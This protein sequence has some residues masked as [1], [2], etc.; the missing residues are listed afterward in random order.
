MPPSASSNRPWRSCR[1]SVKAPFTWPNISLSNSVEEIPPRFTLIY[2]AFFRWLL[3]KIASVISSLPVPLS[4]VIN[5]EA[6]VGAMRPMSSRTFSSLGSSPTILPKSYCASSS[7]RLGAFTASFRAASPRAVF[8]T[9]SSCS[10]VQG[11]VMKST[12][13]ALIPLTAR[14]MEPQAVIMT[15]GRSG[16]LF[17]NSASRAIP[18]SPVVCREKFISCRTRSNDSR[19]T[20][21]R[22]SA[23]LLA[24]LVRYPACL[25]SR[26]SE[27]V[28]DISSSTIRIMGSF[29]HS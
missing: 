21:S 19:S 20:W 4:P 14:S 18:S 6:S 1:A 3:R 9:C 22:A 8:T 11:L 26:A 29:R 13:P 25:S 2:G 17:A 12:A 15:T 7:P 24:V 27:V 28:T 16:L 23:G 5:T 10:L